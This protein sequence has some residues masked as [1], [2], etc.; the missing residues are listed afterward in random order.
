MSLVNTLP[1][2]KTKIFIY[3]L[4]DPHTDQL[5]YV[6]LTKNGFSRICNHYNDCLLPYKHS[7]IKKWVKRL[8]LENKIFNVIYIEYFNEDGLHLDS[9][10]IFW[11]EY[12]KAI[13]CNLLNHEKG[14]RVYSNLEHYKNS[15]SKNL[16]NKKKTEQ[17]AKNIKNGQTREY[18]VKIVDDL[19]NQY[20][21]LQ[22]A[23]TALSV[24]KS[25]IQKAVYG[26]I[27]RC[28][29]RKLTKV[30]GGRIENSEIRMPAYQKK[31]RVS[32]EF[33]IVDNNGNIYL[34]TADAAK[35]LNIKKRQIF[36]LLSG[37]C[38]TTKNGLS[39]KR[40]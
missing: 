6:G 23:A 17:H 27:N 37:E 5:R 16:K 28:K 18:G 20:N 35:K 8:R 11:I 1:K 10:E 22:E 15:K 30:G 32:P 14:G 13:G 33:P 7:A 12:F 3:G 36:R 34:N 38:K 29:G 19:G 21:S 2:P 4:C 9:A 26:G 24:S 39:L 31:G 40:M 25:T